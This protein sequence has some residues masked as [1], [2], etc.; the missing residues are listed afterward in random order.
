MY[1][2]SW[3]TYY[4]RPER[5][6]AN[7]AE[8]AW[9]GPGSNSGCG[10]NRA[11]CHDESSF[12]F[13]WSEIFRIVFELTGKPLR[14]KRVHHGGKIL[15]LLSDME[16]APL[17]GFAAALWEEMTPEYKARIG[18][19]ESTL[20]YVLRICSVHFNRGIDDLKHL[21][22]ET[23]GQLRELRH[24]KTQ[25][26]LDKFELW[27]GSIDDPTGRTQRWLDHKKMHRWLLPALIQ[28]RSNIGADWDL[29][30]PNTN[31]GEGQHR[32]NN[33]QT[34][35]DMG[36]IESMEK[37]EALDASIEAQLR[38]EE[39][40]GDARNPRNGVA[41][42][43]LSRYTRRLSAV[44]KSRRVRFVDIKVRLRGVGVAEAKAELKK[45]RKLAKSRPS[46]Q[47]QN[48][49]AVCEKQLQVSKTKL[50]KAKAEAK[51]NSSGRVSV[52]RPRIS[53][54]TQSYLATVEEL[55]EDAAD[56]SQPLVD[57]V[58]DLSSSAQSQGNVTAPLSPAADIPAV[59][60]STR[61]T[62][63]ALDRR[64]ISE[65]TTTKRARDTE[66]SGHTSR[67]RNKSG[68][69]NTRNKGLNLDW[70][71][72]VDGKVT[73]IREYARMHFD[74]FAV[75]YPEYVAVWKAENQYV[76]FA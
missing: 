12:K 67:K 25:A 53:A 11:T 43:Y 50:S 17:L 40:T 41:T 7:Y 19:P 13:V 68:P 20:S 49:V 35:T 66:S 42:R 44:E 47:A 14:F 2:P 70:E 36:I 21:S 37:Y 58:M 38:Q 65:S 46:A 4:A 32:W 16:A 60:R 39:R 15:G 57:I 69:A 28:F 33:I 55:E 64:V 73:P 51:S 75:E 10:S 5:A 1:D 71:I 6:E 56:N 74:A 72:Y 29:L 45:A 61:P 8:D 76:E 48:Q 18:N 31:L 22:K 54:Q 63:P 26:E 24:V 3:D 62:Q 30:E 23:R 9:S 34:G 52:G 27:L 59:R